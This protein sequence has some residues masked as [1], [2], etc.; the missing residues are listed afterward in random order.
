MMTQ[1][2]LATGAEHIEWNLTDLY[3]ST[4]E[5]G[6]GGDLRTIDKRSQDFRAKWNGRLG[7]LQ[8][9]EFMV[10]VA[11]YESLVET[12]GRMGSYT[13][14]VW[15][16]DSANVEAARLMQTVREVSSRASS[17]L[18]FLGV[19]LAQLP[20]S[21]LRELLEAPELASRKHWLEGVIESKPYTLDEDVERALAA[22]SITSRSSWVRLHDEVSNAQ[23]FQ[24]NGRELTISEI[25]R[26][27]YDKD[28]AVRKAGSQAFIAGLVPDAKM[29]AFVF[30]TVIADCESNDRLHGFPT[31]VSSRNLENEVSDES[32]Q[33]LVDTVVGRYDLVRRFYGVKQRL[34]GLSTFHDYDRNATVGAETANV[35]WDQARDI[36]L[37]A[38]TSFDPQAGA[39]AKM[40][41]DKNWIHAPTRKGKRSGA[42][43]AG[44]IASVHPYVFM[45]Y[46]G[47][48]RDVQTLAHE[49]GHGIHQYLSRQQGPLLMHTPLTIAETASVFGEM[50]TFRKL[51]EGAT[52]DSERLSLVMSKL[53][54]MIA[55][56]FRQ[57]ALNRFEDAMHTTRRA[58]GELS[59]EQINAIWLKTQREQ[60][61]DS[62][63]V[64]P[65]AELTWTYI[66]HFIHTPGYV[67]AYAFGELLVLALYEIYKKDPADFTPKYMTLLAS[68]GSKSP[69]DLLEPFGID[70][71]DPS[72]WN[73]G[74]N[75]IERFITEAE[76]LA[77]PVPS[78]QA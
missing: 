48:T 65:G 28:R 1:Q 40:F 15:S 53:D 68:G 41:F 33:T 42:Y 12:F 49:L 43:S 56:V 2:T 8:I 70:I 6:L 45:N 24:Y 34:L 58:E 77:A 71:N 67:Y 76:R 13:N 17:N 11:E 23:T 21:R 3:A 64:S 78:A 37:D 14:L 60:F 47:T 55:T 29:H 44:T 9:S 52:T 75:F 50:I 7:D 36:V 66:S 54:G 22:K 19:Q 18:I 26:L 31:W 62:I 46:T 51:Y 30:N 38:Y 72:F 39:I 16:T 32:V 25:T 63:I 35:S 4:D 5:S 74:L 20:E 69:K 10:M 57:I 73:T 27:G 61:G 59:V